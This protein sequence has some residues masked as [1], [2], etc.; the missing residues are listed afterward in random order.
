MAANSEPHPAPPPARC[1]TTLVDGALGRPRSPRLVLYKCWGRGGQATVDGQRG[2][3]LRTD[4]DRF[5]V[6][7]SW[8]RA[9]ALLWQRAPAN[10]RVGHAPRAAA[11]RACLPGRLRAPGHGR[12]AEFQ[13]TAAVSHL[14][15]RPPALNARTRCIRRDGHRT[16]R[17]AEPSAAGPVAEL[18]A[19]PA[20]STS[21]PAPCYK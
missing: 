3:T 19:G 2:E 17:M 8:P 18:T 1:F 9:L 20:A 12:V 11:P 7:R 13:V 14:R 4:V 10:W 15:R 5:E 16:G 21:R 6:C